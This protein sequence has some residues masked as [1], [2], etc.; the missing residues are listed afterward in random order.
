M[1]DTVRTIRIVVDSRPAEE[2]AGRARR[3]LGG[4]GTEA[5]RADRTMK[6]LGSGLNGTGALMK[7]AER[8]ARQL[9]QATL[10]L[11]RAQMTATRSAG[12]MRA[13]SMNLGY[14]ISDVTQ[15]IALGTNPLIIF[16]QQG[17]QTAAALAGMGGRIGAVASALSGPWGAAVMGA[18]M[19]AG[20]LATKLWDNAEAA[21]EAA[22]KTGKLTGA[23]KLLKE[24][25]G[26]SILTAREMAK[27]TYNL[28]LQK[29]QEAV[30]TLAAAQAHLE[31]AKA[32][33]EAQKVRASGPGQGN[34]LAA[35]GLGRTVAGIE[36]AEKRVA[37]MRKGLFDAS[38]DVDKAFGKVSSSGLELEDVLGGVNRNFRETKDTSDTATAALREQQKAMDALADAATRARNAMGNFG[39]ASAEAMA[40]S[41]EDA[42]VKQYGIEGGIYGEGIGAILK[43]SKAPMGEAGDEI[44]KRAG[45]AFRDEGLLAAEAIGQIIGG[46]AGRAIQNVV[47]ILEG[48]KSGD[49]TAMNSPLGA[50][51]TLA[52]SK[53][54]PGRQF[55]DDA[56]KFAKPITK[57][58]D[59]IFGGMEGDG[60]FTKA[61][62][63]AI[64]GGAIGEATS[65][66]MKA[67]GIKTSKT[68]AQIGGAIGGATGIPGMDIAGSIVGGVIGGMLKKTKWGAVD[69]TSVDGFSTRGNSGKAKDAASAAATSFQGG[70]QAIADA[71]GADLGSFGVTLGQRHGDWRV[72]TNAGGSLKKKK[73]AVEFDDDAEGAIKYAIRDAIRDGALLGI[74][75]FSQRVLR[76]N[77]DLDKA[78]DIAAKYETLLEALAASDNPIR[79]AAES[80]AKDFTMLANEM[81]KAG[82]TA[83]ELANVETY[84]A[85]EREKALTAVL[86]PLKDY[87]K[88]LSGEGSGVT[89][90][91]R[92]NTSKLEY[93]QA[94]AGFAAGTIDQ[95]AFTAAGQE[96]FALARDVFGTATGEFQ[97]IRQQLLA[98]TA[99]ALE[100]A[101][102]AFNGG[103]PERLLAAQEAANTVAAQSYQQQVIANQYLVYLPQIAQALAS[104]GAISGRY[105]NG[106][107][108]AA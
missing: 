78:L 75:E 68:G 76:G 48:A 41:R 32:F 88:S 63:G 69:L 5:A 11:S 51:A 12:S 23:E 67:L 46:K 36:K 6:M 16:A 79:A 47:G 25:R 97:S 92:F 9:E 42:Y 104:G 58:L 3:A 62:G 91:N 19:I 10:E 54:G 107:W 55:L 2:G 26:E 22:E 77:M 27:Q 73:G 108:K 74:S 99:G 44:G 8:S 102:A 101:A 50:L 95:G 64:K 43:A 65:G 66:V 31:Y 100:T 4:L 53:S 20:T 45:R 83:A 71:L 1:S 85:K 49:F 82:A 15:Q 80:F 14:Q 34:E 87:Q 56:D 59:K 70:L 40:K 86:Q 38:S 52:S 96:L 84:Y 93:E 35:L 39:I 89:A 7:E 13:A 94:K 81:R 29:R 24:L 28:A 103:A 17:G 98:D 106:V 21:D 60:T 72:N 37:E 33:H 57:K 30:D 18:V 90:L 61:L 105:V